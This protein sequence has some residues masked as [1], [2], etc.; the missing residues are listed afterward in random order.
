MDVRLLTDEGVELRTADELPALLDRSDGLV[1]V[2]IPS[3]D[4][5]S[6][7]VLSE[8]F[9]FHPLAVRDCVERNRVPKVHAYDDHVFVVLHAPELGKAVTF[10]SSS[11]TS[12]SDRGTW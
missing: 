4:E 5:A 9:R 12:S 10:T 7:H 3:C 8:V 6:T 11:W 1:W 2:D